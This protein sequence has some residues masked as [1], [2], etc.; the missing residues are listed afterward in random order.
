MT[1]RQQF[2]DIRSNNFSL[3][4]HNSIKNKNKNDLT[5]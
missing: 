5:A 1:V 2:Y 4:E 3:S